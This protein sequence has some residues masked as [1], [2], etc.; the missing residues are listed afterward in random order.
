MAIT[1][2]LLLGPHS[3]G[4]QNLSMN[5]QEVFNQMKNGIKQDI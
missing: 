5:A 1:Q 2:Y 3:N 4:T